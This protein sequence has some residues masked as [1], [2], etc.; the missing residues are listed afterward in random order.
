MAETLTLIVNGQRYEGWTSIRVSRGIDRAVGDF[1]I[2]VT[3]RWTGQNTA[4]ADPAKV[5]R[6]A[7]LYAG[8][9]P[10]ADRLCRRLRADHAVGRAQRCRGIKG[11]SLTEDLVDCTPDIRV[12]QFAGYTLQAIANAICALFGISVVSQADNAQIPFATVQMERCETAFT[13]LERLG[14]MSGVLLTDNPA[15]NL[16]LTTAGST[17]AS[18]RLVQ[19]ENIQQ[20]S[21]T[22]TSH[23]RFSIYIVKGQRRPWRRRR[24]GVES[25][26]S[27]RRWIHHAND[28]RRHHR[29]ADAIEPWGPRRQCE[30]A[31]G[32]SGAR[33]PAC[34]ATGRA[35]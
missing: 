10:A 28:R 18:G 33:M 32:G 20:A 8:V 12:G 7:Q 29:V 5:P 2:E 25:G 26:V 11:R 27:R 19:G 3:E 23:K 31:D 24:L 14:R 9:D 17:R 22:L 35:S 6:R 1:D 4:L 30:D 13:F 16:V 15:G 34:R 21:A